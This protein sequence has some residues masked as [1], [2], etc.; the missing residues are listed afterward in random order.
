MPLQDKRV[1]WDW[2]FLQSLSDE[3]NCYQLTEKQVNFLLGIVPQY[4]WSSRWDNV[5]T[6][7]Q[8]E[9]SAFG[10]DVINRLLVYSEDCGEECGEGSLGEC[11]R[12]DTTT[13]AFDFYPNNP[14]D[15]SDQR[16]TPI[17][18]RWRRFSTLIE[19]DDL[20]D[21]FQAIL[22]FLEDNGGYFPND[23]FISYSDQGIFR[24]SEFESFLDF[25]SNYTLLP[26]P[27]VNWQMRGTGQ[28]EIE[29]CQVPIG[30]AC[31]LSWDIEFNFQQI[32]DIITGQ[33]GDEGDNWRVFDLNRNV[34]DIPPE[35]IPT[36]VQE[37]D[38]SEAGD[39]EVTALFYPAI[40]PTP[41]FFHP[42]GG[43][44]EVEV[45]G[46]TVIG[47]ESGQ[48][49]TKYNSGLD[50]FK[51]KGAIGAMATEDLCEAMICAFEEMARRIL[52]S[53]DKDNVLS[54]VSIDKDTGQITLQQ[55]DIDRE[56]ISGT[57]QEKRYGGVYYQA[58][59]VAQLFTDINDYI[60]IPY[61]NAT[62][63]KLTKSF[64]DIDAI[65][66]V[67]LST[68][69]DTAIDAYITADPEFD[70]DI[71]ALALR[72]FCNSLSSGNTKYAIED[73]A[74]SEAELNLF[75]NLLVLVPKTTYS[76]WYREGAFT[77]KDG[78]QGAPCYRFPDATMTYDTGDLSSDQKAFTI[79]PNLPVGSA[80]NDRRRLYRVVITGV[81]IGDNYRWDGQYL[82]A[83]P[84]GVP[85]YDPLLLRHIEGGVNVGG[86]YDPD[87]PP[88]YDPSVGYEATYTF[89]FTTPNALRLWGIRIPTE[90]QTDSNVEGALII[91]VLDLGH[92]DA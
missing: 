22:D 69:W 71:D 15:S 27:Y 21:W 5:G 62:I 55:A 37:I 51:R 87:V 54:S 61:T 52:L 64:V 89:G 57:S 68:D 82:T 56:N 10:A 20:P 44:R 4:N 53:Q 47:A 14:F 84:S 17:Q 67:E 18:A 38:F 72:Y 59:R 80:T 48:D 32:K 24:E 12:L 77:P 92:P 86:G 36:I 65:E 31:L 76:N 49:I 26:F 43:I 13:E 11:F 8:D 74:M 35:L 6:S 63:Q 29:F 2:Q 58:E 73:E 34:F 88:P 19:E 79:Q 30:G 1:R 40:R 41:P 85:A 46:L 23:C 33:A 39:H 66:D 42:F 78:Y 50:A 3:P 16:F 60:D 81:L 25:L 91:D 7:T 75:T 28:F 90:I 83:L 9:R 45:C 70:I